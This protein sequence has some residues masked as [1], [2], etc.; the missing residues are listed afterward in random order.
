MVKRFYSVGCE[1]SGTRKV[2]YD[3]N[4]SEKM[5]ERTIVRKVSQECIVCYNSENI[6]TFIGRSQAEKK[7]RP[8]N[9]VVDVGRDREFEEV[10]EKSV[11]TGAGDMNMNAVD[12]GLKQKKLQF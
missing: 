12:D 3:G 5:V 7:V 6:W 2:D 4:F 8:I 1:N 11:D 10:K 9:E